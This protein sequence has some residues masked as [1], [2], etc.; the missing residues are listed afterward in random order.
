MDMRNNNMRRNDL[1]MRKWILVNEGLVGRGVKNAVTTV[2]GG[3]G[4]KRN[5]P[6]GSEK[7]NMN[8]NE[9]YVLTTV[10]FWAESSNFSGDFMRSSVLKESGV[11]N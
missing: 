8:R 2:G 5:D 11:V 6:F 3:G 10:N 1:T 9:F 4:I 7:A